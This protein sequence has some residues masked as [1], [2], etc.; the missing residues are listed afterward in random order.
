MH[1]TNLPIMLALFSTVVAIPILSL[2]VSLTS[3][4]TSK[5]APEPRE[6][7]MPDGAYPSTWL[8][9]GWNRKFL[10]A[11]LETDSLMEL[12]TTSVRYL[13]EKDLTNASRY[14]YRILE[15]LAE[16]QTD[17]PLLRANVI[18]NLGCTEYFSNAEQ[19]QSR[20][21][22]ALEMASEN[23]DPVTLASAARNLSAVLLFQ[24]KLQEAQTA[25]DTAK[26][27]IIAG[28][29]EEAR[30]LIDIEVLQKAIDRAAGKGKR[31]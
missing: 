14:S 27:A 26:Q 7:L 2:F 29:G 25:L 3:S 15:V 21:Q 28:W 18:N 20:F 22:I 24:N 19:A 8:A 12:Y 6:P 1:I 13:R 10:K 9:P 31:R 23:G 5:E 4:D 11:P 30:H 16:K 17:F